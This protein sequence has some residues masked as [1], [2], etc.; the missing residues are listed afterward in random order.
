MYLLTNGVFRSDGIK[1]VGGNLVNLN[2][3]QKV[4]LEIALLK[5]QGQGV[6]TDDQRVHIMQAVLGIVVTSEEAAYEWRATNRVENH[7]DKSSTVH[8]G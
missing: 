8:P 1:Y 3:D 4:D 2:E 5:L 7:P 6:I